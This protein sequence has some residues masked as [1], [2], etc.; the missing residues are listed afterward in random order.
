MGSVVPDGRCYVLMSALIGVAAIVYVR[1]LCWLEDRVAQRRFPD[2]LRL[3]Q[4]GVPFPYANE[5]EPPATK[6]AA[7]PSPEIAGAWRDGPPSRGPPGPDNRRLRLRLPP[8]R[9]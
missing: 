1:L 4:R 3:H 8:N 2:W 5:G 6:P 9:A 7:R